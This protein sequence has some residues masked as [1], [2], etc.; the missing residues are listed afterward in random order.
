MRISPFRERLH[1]FFFGVN[2]QVQQTAIEI[3]II[4]LFTY[5]RNISGSETKWHEIFFS[6]RI[7]VDVKPYTNLLFLLAVGIGITLPLYLLAEGE[8][9]M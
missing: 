8:I 6:M 4:I 1:F 9:H 2:Q 7:C 5:V 3:D